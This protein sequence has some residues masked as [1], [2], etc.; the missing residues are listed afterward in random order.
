MLGKFDK[1]CPKYYLTPG[2][3]APLPVPGFFSEVPGPIKESILKYFQ[4]WAR[5]V[6]HCF[7]HLQYLPLFFYKFKKFHNQWWLDKNFVIQY[8]KFFTEYM[9]PIIKIVLKY[10]IWFQDTQK[11][12]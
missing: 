7:T 10:Q 4:H 11:S 2:V 5:T 6:K 9:F 8:W 1:L 12:H 3:G